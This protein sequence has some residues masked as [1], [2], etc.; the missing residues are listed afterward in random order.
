MSN[1]LA[2]LVK[3]YIQ[4]RRDAVNQ[5]L[6]CWS[7]ACSL[8]EAIRKS[9]LS[10][11]K[12]KKHPHQNRIR[13]IDLSRAATRL[14]ALRKEISAAREFDHLHKNIGAAFQPGDGIGELAIYDF[15]IR[16]GAFRDLKP[17]KVYLHRGARD[18]ARALGIPGKSAI[19]VTVFPP[20]L[21]QLLKASEIEDFLCVFKDRLGPQQLKGP[22]T[23][24]FLQHA[25]GCCAQSSGWC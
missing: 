6:R 14:V 21:R 3:S 9:A 1:R 16:I 7:D 24:I 4:S 11:L 25:K 5:E 10:R 22:V 19:P 8:S 20:P 17:D 15:A 18:G 13:S 12:G 2:A 23:K